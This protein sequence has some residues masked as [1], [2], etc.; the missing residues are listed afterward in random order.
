L[1]WVR[2]CV[3]QEPL[4]SFIVDE[5]KP[6]KQYESD[7]EILEAFM[8]LGQTAFHVAGTCR[9]GSDEAAVVDPQ[10]RVRGLQGIR[11]VDTSIMPTLISG[12]TNAPM[13]AMAMRAAE[14]ITG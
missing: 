11:V 6:G 2:R 8:S 7:D 14:I 13:M 5:V 12:N 9:M 1:R 3:S 4:R 10:L